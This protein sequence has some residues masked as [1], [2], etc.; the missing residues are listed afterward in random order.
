MVLSRDGYRCTTCG[1]TRD[2]HVHHIVPRREGGPD[3]LSNL[4]TL[5]FTC[6]ERLHAERDVIEGGCGDGHPTFRA[7]E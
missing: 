6:H 1:A 3:E 4:V 2:L 5:C 7:T